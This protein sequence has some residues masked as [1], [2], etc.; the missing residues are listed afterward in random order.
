MSILCSELAHLRI[1]IKIIGQI[2]VLP[3]P[4]VG[5]AVVV[6]IFFQLLTFLLGIFHVILSHHHGCLVQLCREV[7]L[8]I[9]FGILF[10]HQSAK[11][12][13]EEASSIL[14]LRGLLRLG[15]EGGAESHLLVNFLVANDSI[16]VLGVRIGGGII[17][18]HCP[19]GCCGFL[20]LDSNIS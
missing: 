17:E 20:G 10:W 8:S 5:K 11:D 1:L 4:V 6:G 14:L 18:H 3:H 7:D 2:V 9:V 19:L 15:V 16:V 12:V 13:A